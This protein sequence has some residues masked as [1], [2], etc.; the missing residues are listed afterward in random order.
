MA[1]SVRRMRR[2]MSAVLGGLL[3]AGALPLVT[4][5]TAL[6][7]SAPTPP[8]PRTVTA[9]VLPTV[10]INGVVWD[11]VVVGN[12]VY[13][14]GNFSQARPA[15][16]AA[17]TNQTARSNLLAYDLTTG[18]LITSWA[19]TLNGQGL[20]I[21]ASADGT[22]IYV[23]G[24]FTQVSG[25]AR[26]RLAAIDATT[27]AVVTGFNASVNSRVRAIDVNGDTLYLGGAFSTVGGQPRSRLAAVSATSGALTPWAPTVDSEVYGVVAPAGS[28]TVVAGGR[29]EFAN[30]QRVLGF[31]AFNAADTGSL[32]AWPS[33]GI[34]PNYGPDSAI[35]SLSSDGNQVF[36]TAYDYFG[37][38]PFEAS[39]AVSLATGAISWVNGCI[40]DTYSAYPIGDVLYSVGH[41]HN[42][43]AIGGHPQTEPWTF[44][45]SL[46]TTTAPAADGRLNTSGAYANY[47]AP[48]LLHWLPTLAQGSFTG[49]FQAG[50]DVTGN[51]EYVVIGGEFPRANGVNQQGLV[52]FRVNGPN[53]TA[54]QGYP[55]LQPNVVS[56]APGAA[57]VSWTSAWDR[58]NRDLTYE[59]L[60]GAT[61]NSS[62]VLTSFAADSAWWDRPPLAYTDTTAAPG[63]S[64]TYRVRVR[65]FWG[66]NLVSAARTFTVPAGTVQASPY[67]DAVRAD[68]PSSYWRLGEPTGA[69]SYDWAGGDDLTVDGSATRGVAGALPEANPATGFSGGATVPAASTAVAT[70]PQNF[71]VEA[72]I[73]TASTTGGKIIGFG[74]STTGSSSGYD[75]HVYMTD[76]G[77]IVFGVYPNAVRTVTTS[78]AYNDD[79]W[80]HVV[81]SLSPAGMELFVDG[82]RV[83]RRVDTTSAQGYSG[84]WRIGGDTLGSWPDQPSSVNF[85]GAIDEVAVYPAALPLERVQ[86]HYAA[87]GRQAQTGTRPADTYGA[88]VYDSG[89]E[90]YW[91]LGETTGDVAV[92][93]TANAANGRYFDGPVLGVPGVPGMPGTAIR[94]DGVD[95][96]VAA[97]Q[98]VTNPTVYSEELWFS[99]TTTRGGKLIGFGRAQSGPSSSYDRHVYMLDDGRLTFGAYN[100]QLN[101]A[102]STLA[103]NDGAWHHMV[104]TQGGDGMKLYV[105]GQLVGS[106]PN[107]QAED[108][109]GYWRVGGDNTW[110]GA[111]SNYFAGAVDEVAV[112]A[113]VLTPARVAEHYALGGGQPP[114]ATPTAA[115]T[116]GSTGLAASFDATTST[117]ADGTVAGYAWTFGDG[118][119]ATGRTATHTYAAAGTFD[120][121]LVVTDDDGATSTVVQPLTVAA[122]PAN[123]APTAAFTSTTS[124]LDV[125]FDGAG[126]AD[127]DGTVATWAW[128]FGDG[129]TGTGT[130]PSH[131]Y[132]AAGTYTVSLT[133]TDDDGATG[134][135]SDSLVVTAPPPMNQPPTA[136]FTS[137]SAGLT[138]TFDGAGSTDADGTVATWAWDFGDGTTGTGVAPAHTYAAA[139]TVTVTLT[140]TDDD[141]TS[142]S[143]A[144]PITLVAAP[145]GY[146]TDTF[147]R[148][149]TSGFGTAD[150]G[151]AWTAS[152]GPA[153]D[154]TVADG[155]GRL[156]AAA[157]ASQRLVHL[158]GVS[159][160]DTEVNVAVSMDKAAT[161]GGTY[162]SVLGRRVGTTGDYRAKVRFVAGGAVQVQ[163]VRTVGSTETVLAN[164]TAPGL[165]YAPGQV[166]RVRVQVGGTGTT[167]LAAKVW[168]D[169]T[170]QPAAWLLTATDTTASLQAPG[171]VGLVNYVSGSST[172][173]PVTASFDDFTA[174]PRRP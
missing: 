49:Q 43:S 47:R 169:G 114:N 28:S 113:G 17:G 94:L 107:T 68:R 46:A 172:N 171:G 19:P 153:T 129:T 31:G 155:V 69:V 40:G 51:S 10:Q 173:A 104:A 151:G 160:T 99:T 73:R 35:Y 85:T 7:D 79:Q 80:H 117:D 174:G 109:P 41:S 21:E 15:G 98:P 112:Y 70:G 78:A 115:F 168:P 36:G 65:D 93:V 16:A 170:T 102:N 91:R 90:S 8:T 20:A 130:A 12:R 97:S 116:A 125:A 45:H 105:D 83:G 38:S 101:T 55:E 23:G 2:M 118:A 154:Y 9:D 72:W 126:S 158:G 141:G 54:L 62:T 167:S 53:N 143:N 61:V 63:T 29:F 131:R 100:G 11:Q 108:Y 121:T 111:S 156:R 159:Q 135:T 163:L 18:A 27:G 87:S 92:D 138:A 75:R 3:L 145:V 128:S 88:A 152:G 74:N 127:P 89:A 81:A 147:G 119:T 71:S 48:E 50:W 166:L 150:T 57:R 103:Y 162:V 137:S 148:T 14:T 86:A 30:G 123:T 64:Q 13:V 76:D 95:D 56:L 136:A 42:C 142:A 149:S 133:V 67:G 164:V 58:D 4:T 59:V 39:F 66:N 77:R 22:R 106:N 60:R 6:A 82:R 37:P 33:Y 146:A 120:V 134:T 5:Q 32:L 96:S 157:A 140:V 132:A 34:F 122:V 1:R 161:G 84:V 110:G 124:G 26:P 25:V 44:Q 165:V 24:E 139:G 144:Q 52:R